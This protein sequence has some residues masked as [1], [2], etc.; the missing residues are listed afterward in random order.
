MAEIFV[1]RAT[2]RA[3]IIGHGGL[4]LKKVGTEARKDMEAFFGKQVYLETYVRV[5]KDWRQNKLKLK[6]FGYVD[7]IPAKKYL[8]PL[9]FELLKVSHN[10]PKIDSQKS[11]FPTN[12]QKKINLIR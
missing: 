4:A 8:L 12:K 11:F 10:S 1:E 6:R 9:A 7:W 5:E 2:Q 3:I